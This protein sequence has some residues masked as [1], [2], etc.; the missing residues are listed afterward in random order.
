MIG[1]RALKEETVLQ[2]RRARILALPWCK[3]HPAIDREAARVEHSVQHN[4]RVAERPNRACRRSTNVTNELDDRAD[5]FELRRTARSHLWMHNRGW[6]EQEPLDEPEVIVSGQGVRVTDERGQSWI[7]VNGGYM[8]VHVGY[9]RHEIADAA[10]AQMAELPYFPNGTASPP[11]IRLARKLAEIT[12]GNLSRSWFVSGGSEANET[13]IK[14]ARA[15]YRRA[16]RPG[17]Y[18]I[19]SRAGS[20]HGALGLTMW[21]GGPPTGGNRGDYEPAYPGMVYAP[22]PYAYRRT[23]GARSESECAARC[24]QAVEDLIL[25]HGPDTVAAVIAEPVSVPVGVA[26]PGD[27]YWPRLREI[28]NRYGVMLIADEV[29]TGFGRT[30]KMFALEHWNVVP[31]IMS[32]AKGIVSS[33]APLGASIAREGIANAFAGG[34]ETRFFQHVLTFGGHPVAAA[35]ALKNIEILE[36][37]RLVENSARQGRYFLEQLREL[38][39][40]HRIIGAVNGLGL[41]LGL[42]LVQDRETRKPFPTEAKLADRLNRAFRERRLLLRASPS[43]ITFG[44][45][46]CITREEIDEIVAGVDEALGSAEA[47]LG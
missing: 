7:D 47:N 29:I 10:H 31:D 39:D 43:A 24:A 5:Y 2:D 32:V 30:G 44:P 25:F 36:R 18:K 6:D 1:H 33:Y 27:E 16:G 40:R 12:P 23:C 37:E 4:E 38:Q 46:L 14:I 42:D 13:S 8:S 17:R 41:L 22:Q 11:T 21:L 34:P 9:G 26:V 19:I 20:Y 15:F 45:P 35:A 3:L 28:C